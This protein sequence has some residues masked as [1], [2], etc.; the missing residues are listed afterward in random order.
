MNP[1]VL[2][3]LSLVGTVCSIG[4]QV[5]SAFVGQKKADEALTKKVAEEIAK[6]SQKNH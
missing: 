5:L 4:G 3:V 6:Q 1:K 2:T